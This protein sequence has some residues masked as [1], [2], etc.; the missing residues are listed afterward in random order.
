MKTGINVTLE[1]ENRNIMLNL[2]MKYWDGML[3][4]NLKTEQYVKLEHKNRN[5]MFNLNLKTGTIC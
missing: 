3:Y 5:G 2:N 1:H 4:L